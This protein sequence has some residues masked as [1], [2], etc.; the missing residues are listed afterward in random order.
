[1]AT[2]LPLR[3]FAAA[4]AGERAEASLL[5]PPGAE[6]HAWQPRPRDIAKLSECDLLLHIGAGLEPWLAGL[7]KAFPKGRVRTFEASAALAHS[8]L[9]GQAIDPHI[10][11]DFGLDVLIVRR[12]AE[13][14]SRIAPAGAAAFKANAERLAGRLEALDAAFSEG[15]ADCRGRD[16]VLAGHSA[17]GHLAGRYGLAQRALYGLSPDARPKA[18]DLMEAIDFCR[19]KGIRT[20]FAENAVPPDL[21]DTLAREIKGRVL[22]LHTGHNLSR[23]QLAE[24]LGFFDLMAENLAALRDGLGCR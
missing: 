19:A 18:K 13:E 17:F 3:D 7:L 2:V 22:I 23:E 11:L 1:M 6:V 24:G 4:V 10:W 15:L 12:L 14:L 5:L 20:V 16:I 8:G 21:A 9:S